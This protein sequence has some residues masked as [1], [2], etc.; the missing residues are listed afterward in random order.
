MYREPK[1]D[2]E[3]GLFLPSRC[4]DP[5]CDGHLVAGERFGNPVWH[6]NGLTFH[7]MVGP[8]I[9]CGRDHPRSPKRTE[10]NG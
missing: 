6:C 2:G 1:K 3:T 5:H 8:L 9:A 4:P 7:D 10:S